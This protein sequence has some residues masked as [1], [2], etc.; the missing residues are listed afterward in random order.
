MVKNKKIIKYNLLIF[1]PARSGSKRFKNKNLQKIG[2]DSLISK[3]I[4]FSKKINVNKY[5]YLSTDSKKYAEEGLK[6]GA[7]VP[8]LRSKKNSGDKSNINQAINEFL[9]RTKNKFEFKYIL[10]IMPTQPF[11]SLNTFKKVFGAIKK[12]KY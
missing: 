9:K 12:K 2:K 8:F 10:I 3:S 1:I 11:R 6:Y 5:I 7:Q 4:S